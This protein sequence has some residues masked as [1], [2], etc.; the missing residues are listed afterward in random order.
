VITPGFSFR[1][2]MSGLFWLVDAPADERAIGFTV[3]AKTDDLNEFRRDKSWQ[4][5]G[6]IDAE[7][8]ASGQA[9]QG[10]LAFRLFEH[11]RLPFRMTFRGDDGHRYELS[12]ERRWRSF[13]PL[14]SLTLLTAGLYDEQGDEIGRATL[15]SDLRSQWPSLLGSFRLRLFR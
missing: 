12:G 11:G 3:E 4:L 14:E 2:T 15:R 6:T 9:L 5:S 10:E 8:L 7:R 1:E 13:A